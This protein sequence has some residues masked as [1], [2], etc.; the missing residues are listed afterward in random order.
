MNIYFPFTNEKINRLQKLPFG[1]FINKTGKS[2]L[3]NFFYG[4]YQIKMVPTN[5]RKVRVYF[6]EEFRV[7]IFCQN[8]N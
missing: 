5:L 3:N 2:L 1:A 7:V 6:E 4:C 8:Y